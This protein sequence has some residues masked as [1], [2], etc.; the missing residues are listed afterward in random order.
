MRTSFIGIGLFIVAMAI[1]YFTGVIP[2]IV[3]TFHKILAVGISLA[4]L[5]LPLWMSIIRKIFKR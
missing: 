5:G 1:L 4:T 2:D 3:T